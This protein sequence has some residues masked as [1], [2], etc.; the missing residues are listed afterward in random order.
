M[1]LINSLQQNPFKLAL[2]AGIALFACYGHLRKT[3]GNSNSINLQIKTVCLKFSGDDDARQQYLDMQ[4]DIPKC[5]LPISY[6]FVSIAYNSSFQDL[7]RLIQHHGNFSTK[8]RHKI[9]YGGAILDETFWN[10]IRTDFNN[11]TLIQ[12]TAISYQ[13]SPSILNSEY[14]LN[15]IYKLQDFKTHIL[16]SCSI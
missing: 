1:Q 4:V 7:V 13:K 14:V 12:L 5:S 16:E 3:N 9:L 11:Q 8:Y 6:T 10:T 15:I 2:L